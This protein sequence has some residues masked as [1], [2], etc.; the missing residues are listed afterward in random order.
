MLRPTPR[1]RLQP[2]TSG[3]L[4][5]VLLGTGAPAWAQRF[6]AGSNTNLRVMTID[7]D[8]WEGESTF[9]SPVGTYN[10]DQATRARRLSDLIKKA[11]PDVVV[12]TTALDAECSATFASELGATYPSAVLE[13]TNGLGNPSGQMLFSKVPFETFSSPHREGEARILGVRSGVTFDQDDAFVAWHLYD[14]G[15]LS[16]AELETTPAVGMVRVRPA[17]GCAVNV[18]F[19]RLAERRGIGFDDWDMAV[20]HQHQLEAI[21]DL[22]VDTLGP[23]MN[24]EATFLLGLFDISGGNV[25]SYLFRDAN[26]DDQTAD[27]SEWAEIFDP[28]V[29]Q[30]TDDGFKSAFFRCGKDGASAAASCT[31]D[32]T[33]NPRYFTDGWFAG[34][35][36][37]DGG[38]TQGVGQTSAADVAILPEGGPGRVDYLL[39]NQPGQGAPFLCPQ[40]LKRVFF[41]DPNG[42][43][44]FYQPSSFIAAD[45]GAVLPFPDNLKVSD[46]YGLVG[47]YLFTRAGRCSPVSGPSFGAA[48]FSSG[49]DF[50][51]AMSLG[52][53]AP[54]NRRHYGWIRINQ[55]GTHSIGSNQ[56]S[57]AR[58]FVYH[59][60]DLSTPIAAYHG[61]TNT[62]GGARFS[63]STYELPDPPYYV[64]YEP[65]PNAALPAT[66]VAGVHRHGCSNPVNDFCTLGSNVEYSTSWPSGQH[67]LPYEGAGAPAIPDSMYFV[68]AVDQ[69]SSGANPRVD[70]RVE[71]DNQGQFNLGD[72]KV[73]SRCGFVTN[74]LDCPA[75]GTC[76]P[77][78]PVSPSGWGDADADGRL[79]TVVTTNNQANGGL[80]PSTPG[81]PRAVLFRVHRS[82]TPASC[83]AAKMAVTYQSSLFTVTPVSLNCQI[84]ED[85]GMNDDEIYW[86]LSLDQLAPGPSSCTALSGFSSL[87]RFDQHSGSNKSTAYF[88]GPWGV[89]PR[90]FVEV[91]NMTVCESDGG[92]GSGNVLIGE[93]IHNLLSTPLPYGTPEQS[94]EVPLHAS[95][96]ALYYLDYR[97]KAEQSSSPLAT[98][99]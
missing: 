48:V 2:L 95:P 90:S 87:G 31:F 20:A 76:N 62:W 15:T 21:E 96:D 29:P 23:A 71:F 27:H 82:C 46:H 45:D 7:A 73:F 97:I 66:F 18:A 40:H 51:T 38:H 44:Q 57:R 93:G 42:A 4:A 25:G 1:P 59:H 86:K 85:S 79:E 43:P 83:Q 78:V 9:S 37:T 12:I 67:L 28:S 49:N 10:M 11:D 64:R 72:L 6:C 5:V 50:A 77:A 80:A 14:Q 47:D 34:T 55:K 30:V 60:S 36:S 94:F 26:G 65:L 17:D 61:M 24:R 41:F 56:P 92:D 13:L 63:G 35:P 89:T 8:C 99:P 32:A 19:T 91:A 68:A 3:L 88:P 54:S 58:F 81:S 52:S 39:H 69:A 53:A 33:T 98:C 70:F 74:A 22:V 16:G 75:L 84:E